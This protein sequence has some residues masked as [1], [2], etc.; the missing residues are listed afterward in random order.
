MCITTQL[1]YYY[2]TGLTVILDAFSNQVMSGSVTEDFN[3]FKVMVSK[4]G[5]FPLMDQNIMA[6]EPGHES[7]VAIS[8]MQVSSS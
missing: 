7:F 1:A 2:V 5:S 4:R 6:I 8:A 3:G